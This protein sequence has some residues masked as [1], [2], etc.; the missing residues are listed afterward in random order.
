MIAISIRRCGK[1]L[2]I[3]DNGFEER[4]ELPDG[5]VGGSTVVRLGWGRVSRF[6]L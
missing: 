4:S 2:E 6:W 5:L 3:G 1:V